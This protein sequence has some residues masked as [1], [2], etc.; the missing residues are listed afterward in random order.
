MK[1]K[2]THFEVVLRV[3]LYSTGVGVTCDLRVEGAKSILALRHA[4]VGFFRVNVIVLGI[5]YTATNERL[6]Y[7]A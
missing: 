6:R 2:T 7:R 5:S 1:Q 4:L 3:Q